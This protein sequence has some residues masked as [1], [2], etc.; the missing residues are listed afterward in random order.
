M[1]ISEERTISDDAK[2]PGH[3]SSVLLDKKKE[4]MIYQSLAVRDISEYSYDVP[5]PTARSTK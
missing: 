1:P 2:A 3:A 4:A 5:S